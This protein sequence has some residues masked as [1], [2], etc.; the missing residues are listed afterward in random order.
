MDDPNQEW[1]VHE[2]NMDDPSQDQEWDCQGF[3]ME[4]NGQALA[5]ETKDGDWVI[6]KLYATK[7]LLKLATTLMKTTTMSTTRTTL[8]WRSIIIIVL[9][10]L[11]IMNGGVRLYV[12][13]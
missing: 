9:V 13:I 10:L 12:G 5:A 3:P 8:I 7:T 11:V 1:K 4:F 2:F 6:F